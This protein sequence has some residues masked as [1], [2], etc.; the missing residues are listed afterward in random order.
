[1]LASFLD[2]GSPVGQ[3][4]L[5]E[6]PCLLVLSGQPQGGPGI[7]KRPFEGSVGRPPAPVRAPELE[8]LVP[9]CGRHHP[10]RL[11]VFG[12]KPSQNPVPNAQPWVGGSKGRQF[13]EGQGMGLC[14]DR[15]G[16]G[17]GGGYI[18]VS[19][20]PDQAIRFPDLVR[21]GMQRAHGMAHQ[22]AGDAVALPG[23][24]AEPSF[25]LGGPITRPRG[26]RMRVA[27]GRIEAIKKR[28]DGLHEGG[29]ARFVGAVEHDQIG[30]WFRA[31]IQISQ[32]PQGMHVQAFDLHG[33]TPL[34]SKRR[35]SS[36]SAPSRR[37]R[38]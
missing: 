8:C 6:A 34:R 12:P 17:P 2:L 23:L 16:N 31:C 7:G 11:Q 30:E 13:R 5:I 14:I 15:T 21:E 36:R 3:R 18:L 20:F 37:L 26:E 38:R 19:D 25:Q 32:P 10:W 29:L 33:V 28:T 24:I 22:S 9:Q 4:P 1:M 27:A 35:A